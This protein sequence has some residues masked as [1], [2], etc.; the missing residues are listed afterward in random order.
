MCQRIGHFIQLAVSEL[1]VFENKCGFFRR[2]HSL[3]PEKRM[4]TLE[5]IIRDIRLIEAIQHPMLFFNRDNGYFL[6]PKLRVPDHLIQDVFQSVEQKRN[7]LIVSEQLGL[8]VDIYRIMVTAVTIIDMQL[9]SN[10]TKHIGVPLAPC[11]RVAFGILE[12]DNHIVKIA[13]EGKA[14]VQIP[15]NMGV[16][17]FLVP[18]KLDMLHSAMQL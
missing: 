15:E 14:L 11:P 9:Q 16:G 10:F 6:Q 7:F 5:S 13:G 18:E 1:R 2:F 17:V 8:I 3:F 4:N 12:A